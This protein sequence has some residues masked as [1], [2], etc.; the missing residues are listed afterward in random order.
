MGNDASSAGVRTSLRSGTCRGFRRDLLEVLD[1]LSACIPVYMD[2]RSIHMQG[3]L[4]D[5]FL[6][7]IRS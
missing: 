4:F 7:C 6:G 1:A 5:G 3:L 2:K